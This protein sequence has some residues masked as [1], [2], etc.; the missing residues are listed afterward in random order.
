MDHLVIFKC[1]F[2]YKGT[3]NQSQWNLT[4]I[5]KQKAPTHLANGPVRLDENIF[6]LSHGLSCS[7]LPTDM[8]NTNTSWPQLYSCCREEE[9]EELRG[10][11]SWDQVH[12]GKK[13]REMTSHLGKRK[14]YSKLPVWGGHLQKWLDRRGHK[15]GLH[16]ASS[17]FVPPWPVRSTLC[18]TRRGVALLRAERLLLME[19]PRPGEVRNPRQN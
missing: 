16:L 13:T 10:R 1:T 17:I 11:H 3:F 15:Y 19:T 7:T 12:R 14:R 18:N 8:R 9:D 4:D 5:K 2:N 6:T